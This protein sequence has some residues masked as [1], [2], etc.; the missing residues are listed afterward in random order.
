MEDPRALLLRQAVE[1]YAPFS[2]STWE[3]LLSACSL[4]TIAKGAYLV[5]MG[6][7]ATH[8]YYVCKGLFRAFT[9]SED[10][11][12]YTKI[13]FAENSFPGSIRSL[14]TGERSEFAIEA[15]EDSV[16]IAIEH[17]RYRELLA[18]RD[19]LKWYHIQ[20]LEKNWILAKEP[21]EVSFVLEDARVRYEA[22]KQANPGLL[23]RIPL[24]HIASRLGI[25]PTQLS[26]IR[27]QV[28]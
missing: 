20:Y 7:A 23:S 5:P 24:Q 8:F 25:T 28:K 21:L 11:K 19:D 26:R 16:V 4:K 15:L 3:A 2:D 27:K 6:S 22:F 12:E 18:K 9:V 14:L 13:F 1:A 10:G 17:A